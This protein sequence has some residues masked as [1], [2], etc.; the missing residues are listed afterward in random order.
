MRIDFTNMVELAQ[1]VAT[2]VWGSR[3]PLK[4]IEKLQE[5]VG[6]LKEAIEA[7]PDHAIEKFEVV[8]ELGDV[9]FCIFR[10]ADNLGLDPTQALSLTIVKIQERD[11]YNV[12]NRKRQPETQL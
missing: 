8:K 7:D 1:C 5:E 9:L 11:K 3:D 12:A 4:L 2:D 10:L 6:E